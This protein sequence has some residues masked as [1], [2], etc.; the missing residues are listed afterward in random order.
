[1][2][3]EMQSTAHPNTLFYSPAYLT[4]PT[5]TYAASIPM[6]HFFSN[7]M[8]LY[9]FNGFKLVKRHFQQLC[10]W[11]MNVYVARTVNISFVTFYITLTL[12]EQ[13]KQLGIPDRH[14]ICH[15]DVISD[16]QTGL[17]KR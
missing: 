8:F 13:M 9:D 10:M 16:S 11:F 1:M 5:T 12:C 17:I 4:Y 3:K 7:A 15:A 2:A 14:D 6:N